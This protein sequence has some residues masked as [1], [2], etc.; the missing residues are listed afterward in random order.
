MGVGFRGERC[1]RSEEAAPGD[2][3]TGAGG[4]LKGRLG[5]PA[6]SKC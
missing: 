2:M 4:E 5:V 6:S 3:E 1:G